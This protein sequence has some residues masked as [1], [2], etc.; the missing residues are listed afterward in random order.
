MTK[1]PPTV[2]N[3]FWK[4]LAVVNYRWIPLWILISQ[5]TTKCFHHNP[6][7]KIFR[8]NQFN[9]FKLSRLF[10]LHH[11][12]YFRISNTQRL[13][14]STHNLRIHRNRFAG[15]K[16]C[17]SSSNLLLKQI[18]LP[19]KSIVSTSS[20]PTTTSSCS[21]FMRLTITFLS[22][23]SWSKHHEREGFGFEFKWNE[24]KLSGSDP[25]D[26][27]IGNRFLFKI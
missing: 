7:I 3:Y 22:G 10:H 25:F 26:E 20:S 18:G 27:F 14:P 19:M 8:S 1:L 21:C 5:M 6:T 12:K 15:T 23:F 24:K 2:V 4:K 16:L 17:V 9:S 13:I 11:S